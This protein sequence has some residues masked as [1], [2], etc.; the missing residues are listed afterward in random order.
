M[1]RCG[2]AFRLLRANGLA[3]VRACVFRIR[4]RRG[5][6]RG[7]LTAPSRSRPHVARQPC[8]RGRPR[9]GWSGAYRMKAG[10]G[11][12]VV[13]SWTSAPG[14]RR[15]EKEAIKAGAEPSFPTPGPVSPFPE[16]LRCFHVG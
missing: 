15:F 7:C 9:G 8:S 3:G 10:A 12:L 6:G 2:S 16:V 5:P 11:G 13:G 4:S 14:V 1:K